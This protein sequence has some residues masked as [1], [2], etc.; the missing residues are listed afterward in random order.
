MSTRTLNDDRIATKLVDFISNPANQRYRYAI[1]FEDGDSVNVHEIPSAPCFG[2]L[3]PYGE[4]GD[5]I[6]RP[7]DLKNPWPKTGNPIGISVQLNKHWTAKNKEFERF[8][9][10]KKSPWRQSL[11]D[12]VELIYNKDDKLQGVLLV[13]TKVSPDPFVNAIQVSRSVG[14]KSTDAWNRI[15]DAGA[16]EEEAFALLASGKFHAPYS[17]SMWSYYLLNIDPKLLVNGQPDALKQTFFERGAYRRP[18]IENLFATP[19]TRALGVLLH[20][21]GIDIKKNLDTL[22]SYL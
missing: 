15:R 9:W 22:R 4:N 8:Y 16:S 14:Q 17:N 3:R 19:G 21:S 12:N 1:A 18:I 5:T 6:S 2:E 11:G 13:N 20:S 7:Y 10:G